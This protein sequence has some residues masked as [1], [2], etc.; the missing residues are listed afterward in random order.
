MPERVLNT[1]KKPQV[2][3]SCATKQ[4]NTTN[5][6]LLLL[7]TATL[8]TPLTHWTV[9]NYL[10][11][12]KYKNSVSCLCLLLCPKG[13]K[14]GEYRIIFNSYSSLNSPLCPFGRKIKVTLRALGIWLKFVSCVF[15]GIKEVSEGWKKPIRF[16]LL[17]TTSLNA[18]NLSQTGAV[19]RRQWQLKLHH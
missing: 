16:Y 6:H 17:A 8:R 5:Y 1:S 2:I 18:A 15:W 9:F 13:P 12:C 19:N 7:S 10:P 3:F 14:K 11:Y 4:S